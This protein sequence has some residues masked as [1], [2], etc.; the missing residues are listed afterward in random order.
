MAHEITAKNSVVYYCEECR[1][2]C[3]H[4]GLRVQATAQ[5]MIRE[6]TFCGKTRLVNV[7]EDGATFI[8]LDENGIAKDTYVEREGV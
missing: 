5:C 3:L 8:T 7:Y 1:E 6:C 2:S 4:G